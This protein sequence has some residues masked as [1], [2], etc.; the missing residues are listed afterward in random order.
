MKEI[1]KVSKIG[2]NIIELLF[3]MLFDSTNG[4]QGCW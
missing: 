3:L 1:L 4:D 2:I